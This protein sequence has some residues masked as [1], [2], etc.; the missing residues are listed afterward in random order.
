MSIFHRI[1]A[2][3]VAATFTH[4]GWFGLCPIWINLDDGENTLSE[5]NWIPGW[6]LTVNE[7]ALNFAAWCVE[8][9]GG[10]VPGWPIKIT[11]VLGQ[12]AKP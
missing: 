5:R 1:P 11:G 10:Y 7:A 9:M 8:A 6:W 4:Q 3:Q 12:G 2:A